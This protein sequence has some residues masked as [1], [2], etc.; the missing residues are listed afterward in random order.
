MNRVVIEP[1]QPTEAPKMGEIY[2]STN[3]DI[4]IVCRLGG[5]D[6][7]SFDIISLHSGDRYFGPIP[8]LAQLGTEMRNAA[9]APFTHITSPVT[10]TP[11]A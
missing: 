4:W 8:S 5:T 9:D 3:G 6:A 7:V 10:L 2:Q 11:E 1:E